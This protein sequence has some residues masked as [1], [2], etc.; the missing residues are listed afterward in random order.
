MDG[1]RRNPRQA[2]GR[3]RAAGGRCP[4]PR[5]RRDNH[6]TAP[7]TPETP[8]TPAAAPPQDVLGPEKAAQ[9]VF[10]A[11]GLQSVRPEDQPEASDLPEMAAPMVRRGGRAPLNPAGLWALHR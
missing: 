11:Q 1:P 8:E 7:G 3:G 5:P 6:H 4:A 9:L 10:T 2:P